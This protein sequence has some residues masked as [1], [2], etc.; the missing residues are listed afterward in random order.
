MASM[1]LAQPT[2]R[3]A[4]AHEQH[5]HAVCLPAAHAYLPT[6]PPLR[7][8]ARPTPRCLGCAR[9]LDYA[10]SSG[11]C[12]SKASLPAEG[13]A[14]AALLASPPL[15][16]SLPLLRSPLLL[17]SPPLLQS[18]LN[19]N[20]RRSRPCRGGSHVRV[21]RGS[22]APRPSPPPPRPCPLPPSPPPLHPSPPPRRV[23]ALHCTAALPAPPPRRRRRAAPRTT[24]LHAG[25]SRPC[26][27]SS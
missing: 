12:P 6:P 16:R 2:R 20:T 14:A 9:C 18:T 7:Q 25:C 8:Q 27:S 10:P 24:G 22:K 4:L 15:H 19:H 21:T 23:A 1:R 11:C 5:A 17:R 26:A 13:G 3:A